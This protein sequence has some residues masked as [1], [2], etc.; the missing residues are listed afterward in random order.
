MVATDVQSA[1]VHPFRFRQTRPFARDVETFFLR[2]VGQRSLASSD[3][4]VVYGLVA[5]AWNATEKK[6]LVPIEARSALINQEASLSVHFGM[7]ASHGRNVFLVDAA[8]ATLFGRT[9]LEGVRFSDLQF[10]FQSFYVAFGSAYRGAFPGEPNRIDGAYV[11]STEG[12]IQ[13]VVTSR[14]LGISKGA[15]NWPLNQDRYFY[16]PLRFGEGQT[17]EQ[18][19]QQSI[20][21]TDIPVDVPRPIDREIDFEALGSDFGLRPGTIVDNRPNSVQAD[22]EFAALGF[23]S[24]H[25]ALRVVINAICWLSRRDLAE[26]ERQFP[27]DTP[28]DLIEG[29]KAKSAGTRQR[30]SAELLKR[31]FSVLRIC[32]DLSV[33]SSS[34][35]RP[36]KAGV[37]SHWRRG[38]WRRQPYGSRRAEVRLVWIRPTLVGGDEI[39]DGQGHIYKLE[40]RS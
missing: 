25:V 20:R 12:V 31:G 35:S 4:S 11:S 34:P 21:D 9:D 17:V 2:Q 10:P 28:A 26:L 14:R 1:E 40:D 36:E 37:S 22:H 24:A 15:S 18:A 23:G 39:G 27:A 8:L 19:V 33:T 13:V 7:Y 38:H 32:R 16:F 3:V 5:D 6:A 29:L 30:V